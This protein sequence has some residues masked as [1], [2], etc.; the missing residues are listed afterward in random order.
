MFHQRAGVGLRL[1]GLVVIVQCFELYLATQNATFG[2][3][4]L[5]VGRN[6][7]LHGHSVV[8][9]ACLQGDG[10]PDQQLFGAHAGL[11]MGTGQTECQQWDSHYQPKPRG[12]RK[13]HRKSSL[14]MGVVPLRRV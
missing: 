10:L 14:D 7:I 6:S 13:K 1:G 4:G 11:C 2:V 3:D 12:T 8:V 9:F 5:Q